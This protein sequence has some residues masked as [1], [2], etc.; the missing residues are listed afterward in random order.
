MGRARKNEMR[1]ANN[2]HI[3]HFMRGGRSSSSSSE[4]SLSLRGRER[5]EERRRDLNRDRDRDR[6]KDSMASFAGAGR[7]T[8]VLPTGKELSS[9]D[10][11]AARRARFAT[12]GG[13][14]G[15]SGAAAGVAPRP[16]ASAASEPL[17]T[18]RVATRQSRFGTGAPT[19]GGASGAAAGVAP[20]PVVAPRPARSPSPDLREVAADH[21]IENHLHRT[22][23]D[24]DLGEYAKAKASERGRKNTIVSIP[25][26]GRKEFHR[27]LQSPE[28][29]TELNKT[30]KKTAFRIGPVMSSSVTTTPEGG[31]VKEKK[32]VKDRYL[33][34]WGNKGKMEHLEDYNSD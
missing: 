27:L 5:A 19:G 20:R 26:E 11:M 9:D 29:Q 28:A 17:S 22:E 8:S 32:L 23:D 13:G 16:M 31:V 3:G 24:G 14:G 30:G 7:S 1:E 25:H 34:G 33:Y 4:D 15:G 6:P 12:A 2:S 10:R 18:D 21:F